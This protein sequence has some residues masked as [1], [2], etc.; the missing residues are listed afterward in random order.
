MMYL[1][2]LELYLI[3][4]LEELVEGMVIMLV[5][6]ERMSCQKHML[7]VVIMI[8]LWIGLMV[9]TLEIL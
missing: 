4:T 9:T 2:V 6:E 1:Q 3:F 7:Q 8:T 5:K